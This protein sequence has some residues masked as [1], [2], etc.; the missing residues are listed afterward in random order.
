MVELTADSAYS[1]GMAL[2]Y[3]HPNFPASIQLE[4]Q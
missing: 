3:D 2:I 1:L 4:T